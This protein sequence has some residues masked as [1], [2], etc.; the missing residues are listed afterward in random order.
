LR[1]LRRAF[2]RLRRE[3][4]VY[5]LV[6]KDA[7][8]PWLARVLLGAAIAYLLSPI[9]LIPEFI[10]VIGQLDDLVIVPT[11]VFLALR[12]IPREVIADAR[13]RVRDR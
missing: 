4:A 11:L 12:L 6:L 8:T 13:R 1:R 3:V 9:D 2:R 7:R 5:R 10:P